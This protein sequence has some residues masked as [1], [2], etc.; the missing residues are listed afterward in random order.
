MRIGDADAL[1]RV[2]RDLPDSK[3][4][5]N[6]LDR[7][8]QTALYVALDCPQPSAK[9]VRALLEAGADVNFVFVQEFPGDEE[10]GVDFSDVFKSTGLELPPI[11]LSPKSY[12]VSTI[13]MALKSG[14]LEIVEAFANHGADLH[15]TDDNGYTAMHHA[16]LTAQDPVEVVEY[17][18]EQGVSPDGR[19]S[20]GE[21]PLVGAL[22]D[23]R[24]EVAKLL[25]AGGADEA[26]AQ[27]SPLL[28]AAAMGSLADVEHELTKD[29][30]LDETDA[31]QHKSLHIALRRGDE[32]MVKALMEKGASIRKQFAEAPSCLHCAIQSGKAT[33]VLRMLD[34]GCSANET[35]EHDQPA[36]VC[37]VEAGNL[38]IVQIL[39]DRGADMSI[40][41]GIS[42]IIEAARD[43]ETI[44]FLLNAGADPA[45]IDR[46]ARRK[47]VGL[48][49]END[50]ALLAVTAEQYMAAR[51]ERP[52]TANPE[53]ITEP[54]RLAMINAGCNAYLARDRFDDE[55]RMACGVS[56][57]SRPPQVWC[58]DRFG[59]S[60]TLMPDGRSILIAGEHEDSYDPD[61]C[62]Y[63]D[64]TVLH[65]D[66]TIRIFGYPYEVFEPTDFHS[67][68]LVGDF[69]WIIGGLGYV[70]QRSGSIPVYR[71]ST[72]DYSIERMVT[73]GDLVPRIYEHRANLRDQVIELRGGKAIRFRGS[74]EEHVDNPS[75]YHLN[76][77]QGEWRRISG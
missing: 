38:E 12:S 74:Q 70:H 28:R 16:I 45:K 9:I 75:V 2:L 42:G 56:W 46:D 41:D 30:D 40:G 7:N 52:G 48:P 35:D 13:S 43:R 51:Y 63:N 73:T 25:V 65:P 66:G 60:V 36:L 53:D 39:L 21:V 19:S 58:F 44:L 23:G 14:N 29:P 18:L 62:I 8:N 11:S 22:R 3:R 20:Y 27:W 6:E 61:F 17:L 50:T 59:Q 72:L 1:A 64:V 69:I 31:V 26:P 55:A 37:A 34:A 24:Y 4:V 15:Y 32:S 54:F 71:L 49:D 68:T 76:L 77:E 67:A 57:Q 10:W 47:L 5:I 33:L